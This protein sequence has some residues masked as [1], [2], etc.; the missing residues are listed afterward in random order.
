VTVKNRAPIAVAA[1]AGTR[2]TAAVAVAHRA[3][4]RQ[5]AGLTTH[6]ALQTAIAATVGVPLFGVSRPFLSELR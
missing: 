6:E 3:G 1:E 5:T 4:T 2:Q